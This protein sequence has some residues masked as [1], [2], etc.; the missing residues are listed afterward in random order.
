MAYFFKRQP[1]HFALLALLLLVVWALGGRGRRRGLHFW[2]PGR[3]P[4]SAQR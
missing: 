2:E 1:L 3:A 4:G